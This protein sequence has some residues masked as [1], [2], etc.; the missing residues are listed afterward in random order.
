MRTVLLEKLWRANEDVLYVTKQEFMASFADWDIAPHYAG[1]TLVG[2]TLTKGS[3]FHFAS[4]GAKWTLT[5]AD[6]RRYLSPILAQ[7]GCVTTRTPKDDVR[8]SRFN[9]VVGFVPTGED[10]FYTH[11]KLE[12]SLPKNIRGASCL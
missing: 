10:E 7:Y 9:K 11:Y 12:Q 3:D 4:F 1:D 5:R 2:A 8:Q 6:I